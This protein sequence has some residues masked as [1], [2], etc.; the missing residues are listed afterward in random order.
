MLQAHKDLSSA[1]ASAV[2]VAAEQLV[3]LAETHGSEE[4][5]DEDV[6][7]LLHWTNGLNFDK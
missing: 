3:E 1:T 2:N 4:V 5:E 6:D 7:E